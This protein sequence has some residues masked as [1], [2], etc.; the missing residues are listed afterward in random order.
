M[1]ITLVAVGKLKEKYLKDGISEYVKRL[2]RF[3]TLEI[4]EVNDEKAPESL[5]MA[6]E[7]GVKTAEAQMMPTTLLLRQKAGKVGLAA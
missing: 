5:S 6:E 1:K 3:C 7:T 2:S 4:I